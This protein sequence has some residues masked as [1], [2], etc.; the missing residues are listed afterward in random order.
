[1]KLIVAPE[2]PVYES[3][4]VFLAGGIS[5]CPE[6]QNEVIK[7]LKEEHLTIVNPRRD[8]V[9]PPEAEPEQIRWEHSALAEADAILFWFPA[10]T[11]CPITLFELGAHANR[12]V[13]L[14]IGVHPE[15]ARKLNVT[16]QMELVR[17]GLKIYDNLK[18][19]TEA[20]RIYSREPQTS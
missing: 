18:D 1:M 16:V 6:W 3:K 8:G 11:L 4:S 5:N 12:N 14:F 15:Y 19:L 20:V 9:L 7:A 2:K 17:P 10:E 13:P